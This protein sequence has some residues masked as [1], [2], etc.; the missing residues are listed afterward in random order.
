MRTAS[1]LGTLTL[2]IMV[3]KPIRIR[4]NTD[5]T[6]RLAK[7]EARNHCHLSNPSRNLNLNLNPSHNRNLSRHPTLKCPRWE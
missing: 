1:R 6:L 2:Q 3:G 4:I 5:T 7:E